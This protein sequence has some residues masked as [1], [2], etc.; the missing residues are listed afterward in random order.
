MS[1]I[2]ESSHET[3][4]LMIRVA[5]KPLN[6]SLRSDL[7]RVG[8]SEKGSLSVQWSETLTS[9]QRPG[10]GVFFVVGLLVYQ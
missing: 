3:Q 8:E 6:V 4:G 7:R 2:T 5:K 1:N 9:N 10:L